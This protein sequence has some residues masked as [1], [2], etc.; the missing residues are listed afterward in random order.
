MTHDYLYEK[1]RDQEI[2]P[3][4]TIFFFD[5]DR[6]Y[7]THM[8]WEQKPFDLHLLLQITDSLI[9]KN[10]LLQPT[11]ISPRSALHTK[12][13]IFI[14]IW[15]T[16][17]GDLMKDVSNNTVEVDNIPNNTYFY[18]SNLLRQQIEDMLS[19]IE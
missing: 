15:Q 11:Q 3:Y 7:D 13:V 12:L 8:K 1:L 10:N 14:G 6:W 18:K 4:T 5:Q 9:Y 19:S 17:V 2:M 16:E